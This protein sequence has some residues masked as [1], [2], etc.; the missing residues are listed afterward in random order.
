MRWLSAEGNCSWLHGY[1]GAKLAGVLHM[2]KV[3][4]KIPVEEQQP[5]KERT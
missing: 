5:F 1:N 3:P 4:I 2:L